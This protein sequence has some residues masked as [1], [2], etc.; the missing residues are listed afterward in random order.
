MRRILLLLAIIAPILALTAP[1]KAG[2]WAVTYLDP[3]PAAFQPDTSYT[4]GSWVLQH[5]SHPYW[6]SESDLKVGL[7][8][9]DGRRT[10]D[11]PAV[12]LR[13]PAHYAT[14]VA[15][16]AGTWQVVG[17][18]EWFAPFPLGTLTVPGALRLNPPAPEHKEA[19]A[20]YLS[21]NNGKDPWGTIRPAALPTKPSTAAQPPAA[22]LPAAAP[23]AAISPDRPTPSWW[24][25]PYTLIALFV[26]AG[27]ALL[28]VRLRRRS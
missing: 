22:A 14:A 21:A 11:F 15:V 28:T 27:A 23:V 5:G 9:T 3:A 25:Q 24:R 7:R 20:A 16:P 6:G 4:I 12:K 18:Q 8:F 2:G 19:A 10:L 26:V 17:V 1:A 13:E